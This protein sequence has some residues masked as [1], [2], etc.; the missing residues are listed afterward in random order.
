M[1]FWI[2][3]L[4]IIAVMIGFTIYTISQIKTLSTL[5]LRL[6]QTW[7]YQVATPILYLMM[8]VFYVNIE[9]WIAL[10]FG[11]LAMLYFYRAFYPDGLY[12]GGIK[13]SNRIVYW[14]NV[15]GYQIDT[16]D[17]KRKILK[18]ETLPSGPFKR[19]LA[20]FSIQPDMESAIRKQL[21]E[22]NITKTS[23]R[24]L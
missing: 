10:G 22:L 24:K 17:T 7:G 2:G 19:N 20:L 14:K 8:A 21:A 13:H 5:K 16:D 23:N 15:T 11:Y 9:I 6:K 4:A 1:E 12:V 18:L 3:A